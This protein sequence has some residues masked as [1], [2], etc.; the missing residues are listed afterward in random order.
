[1]DLNAKLQRLAFDCEKHG[2]VLVDLPR[3]LRRTY[4][5]VPKLIDDYHW[6][7]ITKE[8]AMPELAGPERWISREFPHTTRSSNSLLTS[9]L[10]R[11][12]RREFPDWFR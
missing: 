1:M 2:F 6:I 5:S 12:V 7:T 10:E 9:G 8:T 11:W 3:Q 4:G